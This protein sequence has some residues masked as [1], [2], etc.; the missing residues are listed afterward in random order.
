MPR[1]TPQWE[2]GTTYSPG[3]TVVPR[4]PLA[5]VAVPPANATFNDGLT[6]WNARPGWYAGTGGGYNGGACAV[7]SQHAGVDIF[8]T[9]TNQVPVAVG[10]TITASCQI[11][12]GPAPA[13]AAQA[14]VCVIYYDA[15]HVQLTSGGI[16]DGNLI[17]SSNLG[18]WQKSTVVAVAPAGAV[19][20]AI[21]CRGKNDSGGDSILKAD[22]FAWDYE[23]G[24][25]SEP[26]VF[27]ATQA[28]PGKSGANEP[29]WPPT[30]GATVV[31]NQVTWTGG[32]MT[33]V[34]WEAHHLLKSSTTEPAWPTTVGESVHDGSV[35][36]VCVT[37]QVTDP[38]CPQSKFVAIVASKI[39]AADK[40]TIR[41]S[42]TVAPLDWS[43]PN[44][45]GFLP[46][47]LQTYGGNPPAG[48]GIYRSNL[49]VFNT[50]GFQMWQVDE[51]PANAALL[52]ALPVGTN[53]QRAL[54]PVSNDLFFLAAQ[55]VRTMGISAGSS[56]LQAGDVGMPIDKIVQA[57]VAAA[58]ENGETPLATYY[59]SQG[60]YWL[61]I[62][63]A[64]PDLFF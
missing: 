48:I 22:D 42:A 12:Q 52:D 21:A 60:Q 45:A 49:V 27:T 7:L 64:D 58:I 2:P 41:F 36:W 3:A 50:E 35:D 57:A 63:D 40:D 13:G 16:A 18:K 59:P 14:N 39:Y 33:S 25:G 51:D 24:G 28:D 55:G 61:A 15:S 30:V 38:N 31:D 19:Y 5:S 9:N 47:G 10:Q 20:A 62:P 46:Y 11:A 23:N 44:D 26:L 34:A 56:N 29:A 37:P 1:A 17:S 43:S 4:V 32:A 54:S 8:L 53:Q 6:G